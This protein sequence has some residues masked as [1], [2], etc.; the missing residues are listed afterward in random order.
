MRVDAFTVVDLIIILFVLLLG[1][2]YALCVMRHKQQ[3]KASYEEEQALRIR[4][5]ERDEMMF[6]FAPP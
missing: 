4:Q 6:E 5:M 1:L 2:S 3:E